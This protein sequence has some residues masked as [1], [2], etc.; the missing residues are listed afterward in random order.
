[1]PID[2]PRRRSFIETVGPQFQSGA[3]R[4]DAMSPWGPSWFG[5]SYD[6]VVY[7]K[8]TDTLRFRVT[9]SA[10]RGGFGLATG[11]SERLVVN[12]QNVSRSPD[13]CGQ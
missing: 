2:D 12:C 13:P 7:H 10:R 9:L 6:Q 11:V 5:I 3:E 4:P 8:E 1:L